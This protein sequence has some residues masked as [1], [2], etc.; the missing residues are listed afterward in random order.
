[1]L[2]ARAAP[3][4]HRSAPNLLLAQKNNAH[5]V[6]QQLRQIEQLRELARARG[7][8]DQDVESA[9][10]SRPPLDRER[11][12]ARYHR[13]REREFFDK[14]APALRAVAGNARI[15]NFQDALRGTQALKMGGRAWLAWSQPTLAPTYSA[16]NLLTPGWKPPGPANGHRRAPAGPKRAASRGMHRHA[17]GGGYTDHGPATALTG[18]AYLPT[19]PSAA[20]MHRASPGM[21]RSVS[22]AQLDEAARNR[23]G[24]ELEAEELVAKPHYN[25]R[26]EMM[27]ARKSAARLAGAVLTKDED[28]IK[29]VKMKNEQDEAARQQLI[30]KSKTISLASSAMNSRFTDMF[31]AF[32]YVDLDRSGTLNEKEIRRALD[33]W[34]VPLDDEKLK[35][36]MTA[37]DRDGDGEIDYKEFVDVLARDTV[38]PAA[39]GKR[40]MQSKEAMGVD[41]QEMLAQQLSNR[42]QGARYNISINAD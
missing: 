8:S 2:G 11:W 36:I 7:A 24:D 38:A 12:L 22:A 28:A 13:N 33:L 34:N 1:M 39:M 41:A 3:P 25:T 6:E 27:Q 20:A 9:M 32:Q 37:C 31:K 42:Y 19:A 15:L 26:S 35:D 14:H 5:V 16:E 10:R 21:A 4:G 17:P 30:K 23:G 29:L 40:D 18:N